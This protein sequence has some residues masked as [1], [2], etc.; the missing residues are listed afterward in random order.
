[1]NNDC[2]YF[3][4]G[5]N[6]LKEQMQKRTGEVRQ[7]QVCRLADY[8]FAFNKRKDNG[9]IYANIMKQTGAQV[10]GVVYLCSPEALGALDKNEGVK[11]GH[12][13]RQ[14][15]D[16]ILKDG[17]TVSAV[18]YVANDECICPEGPPSEEYL[19][20]ILRGAK[21]HDLPSEYI[22]QIELLGTMRCR[23]YGIDDTKR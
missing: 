20:R 21:Q 23:E 4:Y 9:P 14:P 5:S 3:A 7:P 19:G 17:A 10:W 22:D 6:L 2:W 18:A 1:M 11:T 12:Y 16:V 15:V 13:H 8:R